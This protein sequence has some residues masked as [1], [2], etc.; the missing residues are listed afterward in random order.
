MSRYEYMHPAQD[1]AEDLKGFEEEFGPVPKHKVLCPQCRGTGRSSLYLGSY[2]QSEM[3]EQGPDFYEEY[4]TGAYDRT[5]DTCGGDNV[6]DE[7]NEDAMSAEMLADW[8]GWCQ[9]AWSYRAEVEAERRMG[10]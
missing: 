8:M 2:T 7:V 3:D 1:E 4:M 10:A 6:I 9:D 5:C